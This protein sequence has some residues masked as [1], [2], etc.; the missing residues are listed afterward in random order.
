MGISTVNLNKILAKINKSLE[1]KGDD[2]GKVA[3]LI[4]K[5]DE[6]QVKADTIEADLKLAHVEINK[7][8]TDLGATNAI[9]KNKE[10][11]VIVIAKEI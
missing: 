3:E 11:K 10:D 1:S 7:L 9:L 8:K 4:V 6:A 5:L 2:V